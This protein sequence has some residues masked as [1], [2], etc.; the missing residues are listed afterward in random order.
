MPHI[1]SRGGLRGRFETSAR[2]WKRDLGIGRT[3]EPQLDVFSAIAA[4]IRGTYVV[5][6][7][8]VPTA[9]S[10]GGWGVTIG[11]GAFPGG[12]AV[13][14]Y[15][16]LS[17]LPHFKVPLTITMRPTANALIWGPIPRTPN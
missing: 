2:Q 12:K 6:L 9:R 5:K 4:Q 3:C 16:T 17:G 11:T 13:S 10:S 1:R 14:P 7:K 8:V 15:L